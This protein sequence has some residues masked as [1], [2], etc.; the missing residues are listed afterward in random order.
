MSG[1]QKIE[2]YFPGMTVV[3]G[4]DQLVKTVDGGLNVCIDD[5]PIESD[6]ITEWDTRGYKSPG[7]SFGTAYLAALSRNVAI[8][9]K[10]FLRDFFQEV[11]WNG[12]T[13]GVHDIHPMHCKHA[14]VILNG[15]FGDQIRVNLTPDQIIQAVEQAGGRE[16]KLAGKHNPNSALRINTRDGYTLEQHGDGYTFDASY[17]I[18]MLGVNEAI[19]YGNLYATAR[20]L[21]ISTVEVYE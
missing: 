9:D 17:V 12:V 18:G 11:R 20:A 21:N 7:G 13:V 8:L 1:Y 16:V 10:Y 15:G 14:E 2:R 4:W 3:P 5:R 6:W 19:A